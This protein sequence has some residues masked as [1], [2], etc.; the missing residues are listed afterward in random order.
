MSNDLATLAAANTV[1]DMQPFAGAIQRWACKLPG[2]STARPIIFARGKRTV[3]TASLVN[4]YRSCGY[5]INRATELAA[6]VK[7]RPV[8]LSTGRSKT[9]MTI[10]FG[11]EGG[12]AVSPINDLT[13]RRTLARDNKK[14]T[15]LLVRLS[16][17][18]K[19]VGFVPPDSLGWLTQCEGAI[20][21]CTFTDV[22]A[23]SLPPDLPYLPA[24]FAQ[25]RTGWNGSALYGFHSVKDGQ[26]WGPQSPDFEQAVFHGMGVFPATAQVA[27]GFYLHPWA[28]AS[29]LAV[30]DGLSLLPGAVEATDQ[31]QD[32]N[33]P[34]NT[35]GHGF[36]FGF[37]V[38]T[39]DP[40]VTRLTFAHRPPGVGV[41]N[42]DGVLKGISSG[43]APWRNYA[44]PGILWKSAAAAVDDAD[45]V[46]AF[47]SKYSVVVNDGS[48]GSYHPFPTA[49]F[50]FGYAWGLPN[51]LDVIQWL[52]TD[53]CLANFSTGAVLFDVVQATGDYRKGALER[54]YGPSSMIDNEQKRAYATEALAGVPPELIFRTTYVPRGLNYPSSGD[55]TTSK[56]YLDAARGGSSL[57][58]ALFD[59]PDDEKPPMTYDALGALSLVAIRNR[60]NVAFTSALTGAFED[61]VTVA[62]VTFSR[63]TDGVV[64]ATVG[65]QNVGVA[66]TQI[67]LKQGAKSTFEGV[68]ENEVAV[69]FF[70]VPTWAALMNT[71]DDA[72]TGSYAVDEMVN[73]ADLM[74]DMSSDDHLKRC[75]PLLLGFKRDMVSGAIASTLLGV[76]SPVVMGPAQ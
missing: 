73:S 75:L 64:V 11:P 49:T 52:V 59:D 74:F 20:S 6:S 67:M 53:S 69:E 25:P 10:V 50:L 9:E 45:T 12:E 60:N 70:E 33:R 1:G 46:R 66:D 62:A 57:G 18:K 22:A 48:W 31:S 8:Y 7:P 55:Y 71:L 61:D 24:G 32:V 34:F 29:K 68:L 14:F 41:I 26:I 3:D 35:N 54:L 58:D 5:G 17:D 27:A 37:G 13:M 4:A 51:E 36:N 2:V 76:T 23:A 15:E 16:E 43:S 39:D 28:P 19:H 65:D 63:G 42:T 21:G 72:D 38:P 56:A 44:G 30:V 47:A 40:R